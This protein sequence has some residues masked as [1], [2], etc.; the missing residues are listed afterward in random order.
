MKCH[1]VGITLIDGDDLIPI[2]AMVF[3]PDMLKD[4]DG[5]IPVI[6]LVWL[7]VDEDHRNMGAG[8]RLMEFFAEVINESQVS[9]VICDIPFDPSCDD[10]ITYL[11]D[12][13]FVFGPADKNEFVLN[14]DDI[15]EHRILGK[16]GSSPHVSSLASLSGDMQKTNRR[17]DRTSLT[18]WPLP[19]LIP[20]RRLAMMLII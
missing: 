12:W 11:G 7:Y 6:E 20:T 2:G 9:T 5:E 16:M 4:E 15:S 19:G 17:N 18:G 1:G 13:G 10:L 3:S 8:R 14:W